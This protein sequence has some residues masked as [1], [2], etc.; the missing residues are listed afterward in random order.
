MRAS[1]WRRHCHVI[2]FTFLNN[3]FS[4]FYGLWI[5]IQNEIFCWKA[6][7]CYYSNLFWQKVMKKIGNKMLQEI[8]DRNWW[9]RLVWNVNVKWRNSGLISVKK[10]KC[11]RIYE[12]SPSLISITLL[13]NLLNWN[14]V[15]K[16]FFDFNL[17]DVIFKCI[18]GQKINYSFRLSLLFDLETFGQSLTQ[19]HLFGENSESRVI[20]EHSNTEVCHLVSPQGRIL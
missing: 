17:F 18:K 10:V 4:S 2:K 11:Q 16:D 8:G 7:R 1:L 13:C 5:V 12:L 3:N 14:S 6:R 19:R 9:Q 20:L 15:W